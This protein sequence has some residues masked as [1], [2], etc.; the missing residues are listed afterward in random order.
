MPLRES[1]LK[2]V[3]I[4]IAFFA[5]QNSWADLPQEYSLRIQD[6]EKIALQT[7]NR[8]KSSISD[9]EAANQQADSSRATLFPRLSFEGNYQ[10]LGTVPSIQIGAAPP[11]QLGSSS[12][13]SIGPVLRYTLWD[14]FSAL[15]SFHG[16]SKV[17]EAR[18]EDRKN[19]QLQLLFATRSAYIRVELALEELRLVNDSLALARAQDKDVTNRF[20][21]GAAARLDLVTS[22]RGVLSYDLQFS[23][24][25]A[26]L[27]SALKDLLAV[28]DDTSPRDVS[29]PGPP[30]V[31]NVSLVLNLDPFEK[32]LS[33][34]TGPIAPPDQKQPQI[35]SQHLLVEASELTAD[36]QS[37]K[38]YPTLQ[39]SAETSLNYPNGPKLEQIHQNTVILGFSMPLYLGDPTWHQVSQTRKQ[40]ESL[41]YREDQLRID[42]QR[43]FSKAQE[44]LASLREQQV[45]AKQDIQQSEE[46]AKLYYESYRAG[47]INLIDVQNADV[48]ALQ[49]KVNGARIDAQILNQLITLKSLSGK[50]VT[51]D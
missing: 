22:H 51:N 6:A 48:Q 45:L 25:Q 5:F 44:M 20:H 23:Q 50:E 24:K 32:L 19:A 39:L 42:I 31:E 21:A 40:A 8:L 29:H 35:R 9:Q 17:A 10:Y 16:L 18:G 26:D 3:L 37:A 33:E 13:Y 38:L 14:T 27:S 28:L 46:A 15:K 41:R 4:G 30:H 11:I 12:N 47:K 43:D 2:T 1:L 36:S 34:N 7:S 49:S